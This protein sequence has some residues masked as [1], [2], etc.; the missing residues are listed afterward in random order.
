MLQNGEEISKLT[1]L[2]LCVFGRVCCECVSVRQRSCKAE[3]SLSLSRVLSPPHSLSQLW[4]VTLVQTPPLPSPHPCILHSVSSLAL[5][6]SLSFL[7]LIP[8]RFSRC[9]I[10]SKSLDKTDKRDRSPSGETDPGNE[11]VPATVVSR[12][13][14]QK[15]IYNF[16]RQ[17]TDGV[18]PVPLTAAAL[19]QTMNNV[20]ILCSYTV[21]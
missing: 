13:A 6:Q 11:V 12:K 15:L 8:Q 21:L 18:V 20:Y 10:L 3:L 9:H 19:W 5:F 4:R 14:H 16:R 1:C 17:N 7:L 2:C